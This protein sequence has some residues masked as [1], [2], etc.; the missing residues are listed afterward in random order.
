MLEGEEEQDDIVKDPRTGF[1]SFVC[2]GFALLFNDTKI[3][4]I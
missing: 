3:N 2:D 1:E 4:V